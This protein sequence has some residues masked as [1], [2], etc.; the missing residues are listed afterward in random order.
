MD[1]M[2]LRGDEA[3]RKFSRRLKA[4]AFIGREV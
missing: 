2:E 4:M 3:L 1:I